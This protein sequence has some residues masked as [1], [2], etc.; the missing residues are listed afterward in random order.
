MCF[1]FRLLNSYD[2]RKRLGAKND[3]IL[4]ENRECS[5]VLKSLSLLIVRR[6]QVTKVC[7]K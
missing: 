2:V 5:L 3:Q 4:G 1:F 7:I 6:I